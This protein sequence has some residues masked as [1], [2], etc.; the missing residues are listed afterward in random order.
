MLNKFADVAQNEVLKRCFH[1]CWWANFWIYSVCFQKSS[2]FSPNRSSAKL[3]FQFQRVSVD[4]VSGSRL[5]SGETLDVGSSRVWSSSVRN[6]H[7]W[8]L[9]IPSY[10]TQSG[11]SGS[12]FRVRLSWKHSR[13]AQ[14]TAALGLLE[15][16]KTFI[17]GLC[18]LNRSVVQ[19]MQYQD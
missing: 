3:H 1:L 19:K 11:G 6:G 13:Q 5:D 18:F 17:A 10:L 2:R 16:P 8:L 9:Q 12:N 15:L 4:M 14:I 7:R